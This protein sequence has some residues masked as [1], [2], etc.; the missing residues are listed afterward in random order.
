MYP[1]QSCANLREKIYM[2]SNH[3]TYSHSLLLVKIK[4][5]LSFGIRYTPRD[6]SLA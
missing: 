5:L 1:V 4:C 3:I 6:F 2:I